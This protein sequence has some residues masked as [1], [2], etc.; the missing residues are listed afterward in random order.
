VV[1]WFERYKRGLNPSHKGTLESDDIQGICLCQIDELVLGTVYIFVTSL[2]PMKRL[3]TLVLSQR[4][5][6]GHLW[7]I[8]LLVC[9]HELFSGWASK[10][11]VNSQYPSNLN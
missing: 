9:P 8:Q 11:P 7:D 1:V 6:E 5:P 4:T 3:N 2:Q 10:G